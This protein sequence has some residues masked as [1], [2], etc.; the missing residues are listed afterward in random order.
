[1]IAILM[2]SPYKFTKHSWYRFIKKWSQT[3]E[4]PDIDLYATRFKCGSTQIT[5]LG[6]ED[7][8]YKLEELENA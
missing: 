2:G 5:D 3:G 8:R 4:M 6:I 1:M 7:V